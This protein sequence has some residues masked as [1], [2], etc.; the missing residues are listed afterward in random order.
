MSTRTSDCPPLLEPGEHALTIDELR[1]LCVAR[2]PLSTTRWAIMDGFRKIV[3]LLAAQRID[4]EILVD[5]SYITE[6]IQPDDIDFA[7]VVS[8]QFYDASTPSQRKLLD[9]IGDDFT[10]SAT[11]LCDCQLCVN[12]QRIDPEWFE[13]LC[14]REWWLN[15]FSKSVVY[16]RD[17]GI[18]VLQIG[19]GI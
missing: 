2:F 8:R 7:V 13:G 15:F 18:A 17:R 5:G 6:E 12:Y 9:W 4:C 10:I 16:K 11:Y 14:D 19:A 1:E 3:A